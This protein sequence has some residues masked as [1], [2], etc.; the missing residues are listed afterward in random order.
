MKKLNLLSLTLSQSLLVLILGTS[1]AIAED[2]RPRPDLDT[3]ISQLD[4]TEEKAQKLR[5]ML[6]EHRAEKE[7][8]R[9]ERRTEHEKKRAE[10]EQ[11]RATLYELIG[12]EN[13][14]KFDNYMRQ[15]GPKGP[16]RP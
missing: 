4:I 15:F 14:Y 7:N 9:E 2:Q 10:R 12:A 3:I 8:L 1:V 6:E 5:T 11:H 16:R 13:L